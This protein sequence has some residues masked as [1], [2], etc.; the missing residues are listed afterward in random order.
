VTSITQRKDNW[1]GQILR[2]TLLVKHLIQR[3]INGRIEVTERRGRRR[4]KL[5]VDLKEKRGL[6]ELKRACNSSHSV[7]MSLRRQIAE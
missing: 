6:L 3:K 7:E 1:I 4:K 2:R 5:L